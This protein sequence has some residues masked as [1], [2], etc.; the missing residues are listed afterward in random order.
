MLGDIFIICLEFGVAAFAGRKSESG[1]VFEAWNGHGSTRIHMKYRLMPCFDN[2]LGFSKK[3]IK[4]RTFCHSLHQ[5]GYA[6][7]YS[8]TE[9]AYTDEGVILSQLQLLSRIYHEYHPYVV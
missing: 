2:S 7:L 3:V 5:R 8:S 1:H 9:E 6:F 4:Q